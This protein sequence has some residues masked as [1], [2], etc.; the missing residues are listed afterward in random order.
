MWLVIDVADKTVLRSLKTEHGAKC[1]MAALDKRVG[2]HRYGRT[3]YSGM[4]TS[5]GK[6]P[7]GTYGGSKY[8]VIHESRLARQTK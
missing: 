5:Y 7:D 2:F 3:W 4:E 6:Y 8:A 1:A